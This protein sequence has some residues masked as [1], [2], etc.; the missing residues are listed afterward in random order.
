MLVWCPTTHLIHFAAVKHI[1]NITAQLH[2]LQ[3]EN[4]EQAERLYRADVR[5]RE[6]LNKVATLEQALGQSGGRSFS[7]YEERVPATQQAGDRA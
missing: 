6:L 1:E 2:K 3:R 4:M 7:S 5:E